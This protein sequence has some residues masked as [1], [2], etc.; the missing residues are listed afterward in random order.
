MGSKFGR[1]QRKGNLA[2]HILWQ[3]TVEVTKNSST[4]Q[5]DSP[6]EQTAFMPYPPLAPTHAAATALTS[7][8]VQVIWDD[9]AA[10]ETGY[11]VERSSDG[12]SFSSLATTSANVT[13]YTDSGLS[14]L[15]TYYYRIRAVGTA[16]P[17][18]WSNT[19]QATTLGSGSGDALAIGELSIDG[20]VTGSYL[21]TVSANGVFEQIEELRTGGRPSNRVTYLEHR[22]TFNVPAGSSIAFHLRAWKTASSDGD[23]FVFAWSTD[24]VN[25]TNMMTVTGTS[26][27]G[28]YTVAAL[29]SSISGTVFVRVMDTDRTA[30][31]NDRDSIYVEHM[32]IRS[33]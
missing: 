14:A 31:S 20:S 6:H 19:A 8:S 2:S 17:S 11:E 1:G 27:P 12:V 7:S 9:N 16:G 3:V 29:P 33:Q 26:D 25:Y 5:P 10:T 18:G 24:D 21:D 4:L 15:T 22:W 23:D 32:F 28:T 30:G 13:S